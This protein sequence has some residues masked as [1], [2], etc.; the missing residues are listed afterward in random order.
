MKLYWSLLSGLGVLAIACD[1]GASKDLEQENQTLNSG[2]AQVYL[3]PD[4]FPNLTHKCDA[5]TGMWTTTGGNVWIVYR[6]PL[7]GGEGEITVFDNIP[8]SQTAGP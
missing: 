5:T 8:G 3:M 7:C 2:T 4:K 1:T 6:D